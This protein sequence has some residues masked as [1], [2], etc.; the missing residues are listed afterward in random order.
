MPQSESHPATPNSPYYQIDLPKIPAQYETESLLAVRPDSPLLQ[1]QEVERF[2]YYFRREF[3]YDFIPFQAEEI[4]YWGSDLERDAWKD[5]PYT[6][7]FFAGNDEPRLPD[8]FTESSSLVWAGAGCFYWH[9]YDDLDGTP[10]EEFA[11]MW[12]HPYFRSR[13]I[14]SAHWQAL[15][16]TH[17]DFSALFPLSA[18]MRQFL[19]KHNK[20]SLWYPKYEGREPDFTAIKAN[21]QAKQSRSLTP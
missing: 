10:V 13:G 9:E 21:L 14:L 11:W 5:K 1:R 19:L 20:D 4:T 18:P 15:R 2:A 7:Y 12:L 17:G 8:E 6:A 3:R 16:R